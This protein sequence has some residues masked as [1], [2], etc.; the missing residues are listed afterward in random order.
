[1]KT[2]QFYP[3]IQTEDV[4]ATADFYRTHFGFKSSFDSDWYVHLQSKTDDALNITVLQADH[5]T[6]P[7]GARGPTKNIILSFEVEDVDAE[8]AR[9]KTAGVQITQPLRDEPHGQRHFICKDPNGILID[10]ITPI[11]PSEEFLSGYADG[12]AVA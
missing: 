2:T 5:E 3:L 10:I 7:E 12:V 6:I 4:K 11:A 9:L 8:E 1:M